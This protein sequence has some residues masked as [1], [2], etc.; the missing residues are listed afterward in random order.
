[1]ALF[2]AKINVVRAVRLPQNAHADSESFLH[3]PSGYPETEFFQ[4]NPLY[5]SPWHNTYLPKMRLSVAYG[6]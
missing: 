3:S 5:P 2:D 4:G 6:D 1:M